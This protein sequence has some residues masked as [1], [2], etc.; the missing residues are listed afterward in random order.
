MHR[1]ISTPTLQC[2][3][4]PLCFYSA[5]CWNKGELLGGSWAG[6]RES[7]TASPRLVPPTLNKRISEVEKKQEQQKSST[8]TPSQGSLTL[9][10]SCPTWHG[11][12]WT[13]TDL[14]LWTHCS[15]S[16]QP[17]AVYLPCIYRMPGGVIVGNSGLCC[18]GPA[19][20]VWRQLFERN[21]F[22]LFVDFF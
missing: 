1:F 3:I 19:L 22:T 18:C 20:N 4:L 13:Q 7:G 12:F 2:V 14:S 8:S 16:D 21:Y 9:A 10:A 11:P 5:L 15:Q 6:F 17:C